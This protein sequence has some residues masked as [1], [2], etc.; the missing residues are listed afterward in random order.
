MLL[1]SGRGDKGFEARRDMLFVGALR[2]DESPNVD[3]LLWFIENS[4]PAIIAG[5]A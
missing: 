5:R 1:L 2:E 3:S 4:L